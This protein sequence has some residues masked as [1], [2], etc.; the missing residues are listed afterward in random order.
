M[1]LKSIKLAGFK[2]FVDPT[3]IPI[4]SHM[5][6]IIGPNGCGKSN[7]IDAIRW[8]IGE[9]SAK[10]LR[11][12]SMEDVIFNGTT[13]RKR[14]G[15]AMIEL[16]FDNNQGRI[17]GEYAKFSQIA[18]RREVERGG[19]SSYFLNGTHCRRRDILDI[20]LGTGLGPRSYSIIE[21]GMVSRLIEAKPEE[22]R[23]YLEEAAGISKYKERRRETENRIRHT[24]ENL[25]RLND[26]REELD[27]QLR[28]LKRQANAAERYKVLKEE[29]RL[30][31][32][33]LQALRWQALNEKLSAHND[34]ITEKE[35][36]REEQIANQRELETSIEKARIAQT[37]FTEEQN[38]V[39]KEY[40]GLGAEI[41]RI[42]QQIQSTKEQTQRWQS[43]LTEAES[44]WEEL[45]SSSAE[46][47]DQISEL[48]TELEQLEPQTHNIKSAV[49]EANEAFA[50]AE[51]DM[52]DWQT[53]FDQHQTQ[54]TET[55][56][57]SSVTKTRIENFQQQL[58]RLQSRRQ[59]LQDSQNNP[60]LET[61]A[62][63]VSPLQE[64]AHQLND[65]LSDIEKN[66]AQITEQMDT[67]RAQ[68]AELN[69]SLQTL[70][71][72]QK[73]A[74]ARYASLDALQQ[75]ALGND[76][77]Q[78]NTWL[79]NNHL[80]DKPRLGQSMQVN[81]G[82]EVAAETVLRGCFN[83]LCVDDVSTWVDGLNALESGAL[84]LIDKHASN[85][86]ALHH[87]AK[88]LLSQIQ[89]DWPIEPWVAGVYVAEN[90]V[91]AMQLR[92]QLSANES[93]IT[94]E[95]VWLGANWI[96]VAKAT[97]SSAGVLIREQ[98]LAELE[99]E[100]AQLSQEVAQQSQALQAGEQ[101]LAELENER[102]VQ[103]RAYQDMSTALREAQASL[104][105]K[106]SRLDE[107]QQQQLRLS[108]EA[109]DCDAQ[110]EEA[111]QQLRESHEKNQTLSES[112]SRFESEKQA[113]LEE[114]ARCHET[115]EHARTHAN[116]ERQ[117]ADELGIRLA[118]NENQLSLLKQ[119]VN[120]AE[121]QLD[122]L[123]ERR[124]H[125]QSNLTE[126]DGPLEKLG[127]QLQELL[128]QRVGIEQR[129]HAAEDKLNGQNTQIKQLETQR[130][131]LAELLTQLQTAVQTLQME[132]QEVSVRQ[133]TIKEQLDE[134]DFELDALQ[135]EMP[136]E[137]NVADWETQ[138]EKTAQKITRLGAINLAAIDEFEQQNE[139]KTYLDKQNDDL[140]EALD[141]L[142]SAI[143]KIDRETRGRFKDTF[144]KVNERFKELFPG[145]FGG[146]SACLELTGD[147]LLTTGVLVRAQPPGKRNSTIH[148]LSGG[149]KALTAIA[150]VFSMFHLNP[151]PFCILDEVDAPLDDLN[152]GRFCKVVKEMSAQTQFI[153][154]S[155]NKVT[156]EAADHLMGVTMQEAGVS[157]IV[158]VDMEEAMEMVEA[159]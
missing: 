34:K 144:E 1:Y 128:N 16:T 140:M 121:R 75:S 108:Q 153:V 74:E 45:T 65:Q 95:G 105:A 91:E 136:E 19:Q 33:Q 63:E 68:N 14:V 43:E 7:V 28:H 10:Q 62:N 76:D 117:R 132:R 89:T 66:T 82:W 24:K 124:E 110:L 2:S 55:S 139:R 6:A 51:A 131:T 37:E 109:R 103:Q 42:E 35:N 104:S 84:T 69:Q 41:A 15:K 123:T 106:Q 22:L 142:E 77:E 50:K 32:A 129:L 118:S 156:I 125:L 134:T 138:A 90:L 57:D 27:K 38:A 18:V 44:V 158:S 100:L 30:L 31:N 147:D 60:Q 87:K 52:Q 71:E 101:T 154:I 130:Q 152:V 20:F 64:R 73:V 5:N 58:Q 25:D 97:D 23:V 3:T 92:P 79:D 56:R 46:Q 49:M 67:R 155:H 54:S 149:E 126:N 148:M 150:M 99:K 127:A 135:K 119:T 146:G 112:L 78:I 111:Q 36:E 26:L 85:D 145:I 88:T 151:A 59:T 70:R 116:R 83:A 21:Q 143:H 137:A 159:A 72:K 81:A 11:G 157:R 113:L 102:R 8:V 122:K 13:A 86:A 94:K 80:K 107:L 40:Y 141:V 96:R 53:R 48:T 12:Q 115:L 93:V 47:Q 120:R 98:E 9:T 133:A 4:R 61:L 17:T 114:R 39:Q 29:E